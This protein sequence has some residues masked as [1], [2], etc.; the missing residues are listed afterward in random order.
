MEWANPAHSDSKEVRDAIE[1]MITFLPEA[2]AE[3]IQHSEKD[4]SMKDLDG[5]IKP[6]RILSELK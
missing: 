2:E 3:P 1:Y 6:K 5:T 4:K